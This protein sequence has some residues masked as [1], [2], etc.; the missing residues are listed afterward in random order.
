MELG[1][2]AS[3]DINEHL[4]QP[5]KLEFEKVYFPYLL[6][7]KK[8]YSGVIWT[9]SDKPDRKDAKGLETV[10]RDNCQLAKITLQKVLDF[11]MEFKKEE[12]YFYIQN[13]FYKIRNNQIDISQFIISK[14]LNKEINDNGNKYKN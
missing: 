12:A 14:G 1:G 5:I 6:L 3:R 2:R 8:R 4:V 13:I 9:K 7:N 10:R 11:L